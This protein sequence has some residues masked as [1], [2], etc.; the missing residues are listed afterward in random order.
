MPETDAPGPSLVANWWRRN[1]LKTIASLAIAAGFVWLLERGAL[2]VIP[3]RAAFARV[4][5]WTVAA[6]CA[7]LL[8]V[9]LARSGRWYWLLAPI[10]RMPLRDILCTS[11]I[12]FLAILAMPFRTGEVVRPLLIR[13]EG[14]L[15]GWAAMGTVAAERI[16]DGLTLSV[17]LFVALAVARPLDPLPDHIGAL[18]VPA[19]AVPS[20]A[21][22]AVIL[23]LVAFAV[24]TAFY[25]ARD[26]A[27]R[28]TL[29]TVGRVSERLGTWLASRLE[30]LT[31]GFR[32]LP[33]ARFTVPFALVTLAYWLGNAASAW[34][35]AWGCGLDAI[36]YSQACTVVG[37][38]ALGI[39]VP[40]APGFFG[41]FQVSA[42][43]AL[44]MFYPP[45]DVAGV[46]SAYVLLIYVCQV[47]V[48]LV[49]GL[50]A[51]VVDRDNVRRALAT[52]EAEDAPAA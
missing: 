7:C 9:H 1:W 46:G 17:I 52:A 12:G 41:A 50:G 19:A 29:A 3:S 45:A 14:T 39:L 21:R 36:T 27:R 40:N 13:R 5:W 23:F 42:Y 47:G 11:F 49:V 18:P 51:L 37:V 6:Y 28:L 32:F 20:A 38:V 34:L 8:G 33:Q 4:R 16:L 2:P 43:A 48:T 26:R 10:R 24:M 22:G 25:V 15:S 44:A 31:D 35:L 30:Q